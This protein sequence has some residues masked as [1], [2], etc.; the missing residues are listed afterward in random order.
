MNYTTYKEMMKA[1]Q[2]YWF[3]ESTCPAFC[4]ASSLGVTLDE[5]S[6][7]WSTIIRKELK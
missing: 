7:A 3:A 1:N 6:E 2:L 5:V 4:I